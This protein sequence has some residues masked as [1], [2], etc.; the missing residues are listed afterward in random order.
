MNINQL[1]KQKKDLEKMI[2]KEKDYLHSKNL[3]DIKN[4]RIKENMSREEIEKLIE[5][6][7]QWTAEVERKK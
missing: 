7:I 5:L 3:N 6:T 4:F 1:L 2:I